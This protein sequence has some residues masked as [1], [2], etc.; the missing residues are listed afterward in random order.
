MNQYYYI[1][2][3]E[4]Q[5]KALEAELDTAIELEK[6][7]KNSLSVGAILAWEYDKLNIN[8]KNKEFQLHN[9]L[10]HLKIAKMNFMQTL[11]LNPLTK[12]QLDKVN[13]E[14]YKNLTL[15]EAIYNALNKNENIKIGEK[16]NDISDDQKK[17]AISNFLPK[18]VLGGGYINNSNSVLSDPD[19]L[20][21]NVSAAVSLFNGFKNINTYKKSL[22]MKGISQLKLEK[23]YLRIII[24]TANAYTQV[25]NIKELVDLQKLNHKVEKVKLKQI[26]NEEMIGNIGEVEY[27][28]AVSSYEKSRSQLL[29]TEYRYAVSQGSLKIAM[30]ENLLERGSKKCLE[31]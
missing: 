18:I 7:G 20:Y 4:S 8:I 29:Q 13:I 2:A 22:K 30:G 28:S 9:N 16:V 12:F 6:K 26:K 11:N 5:K 10:R 27:L 25:E 31:K 24:E 1:L 14:E 17:M 23:E 15:E 21:T 19:F 3:L